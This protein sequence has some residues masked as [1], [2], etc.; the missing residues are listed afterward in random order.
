MNPG[1]DCMAWNASPLSRQLISADPSTSGF[2]FF[3]FFKF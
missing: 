3:T 2:T 1:V